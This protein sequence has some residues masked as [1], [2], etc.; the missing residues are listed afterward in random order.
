MHFIVVRYNPDRW[1]H[2]SMHHNHFTNSFVVCHDCFFHNWS[3]RR[4]TNLLPYFG[5]PPWLSHK[6]YL[7]S[8]F[9]PVGANNAVI[10]QGWLRLHSL[11]HYF[12]EQKQLLTNMLRNELHFKKAV[13]RNHSMRET[14]TQQNFSFNSSSFI[15]PIL[16][17]WFLILET[18]QCIFP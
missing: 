4:R 13:G 7:S 1:F 17:S 16:V 6:H 5:K 2:V 9:L 10:L 18:L 12:C 8:S 3:L 15:C 11:V 14:W